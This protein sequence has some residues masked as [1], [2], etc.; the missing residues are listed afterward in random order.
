[1][2][3]LPATR[4][5]AC[6]NLKLRKKL[7]RVCASANE[8]GSGSGGDGLGCDSRTSSTSGST[9]VGAKAEDRGLSVRGAG[10]DGTVVNAVDEVC[11]LAETRNV[12]IAASKLLGLS[13]H[14][15]DT[16]LLRVKVSE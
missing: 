14:A 15:G 16:V 6:E 13:E 8:N 11:V 1:M 7:T 10:L 3:G 9:D 12:R 5:L 4:Y 2:K